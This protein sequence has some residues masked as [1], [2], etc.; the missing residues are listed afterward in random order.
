MARLTY[1][2]TRDGFDVWLATDARHM[3]VEVRRAGTLLAKSDAPHYGILGPD[4][5]SPEKSPFAEHLID[6]ALSKALGRPQRSSFDLLCDVI[7]RGRREKKVLLFKAKPARRSGL[8]SVPV[9]R[10]SAKGGR[11]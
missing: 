1:E 8:F 4:S 5:R 3:T 2:T 9:S 6:G 10:R 7:A 11:K